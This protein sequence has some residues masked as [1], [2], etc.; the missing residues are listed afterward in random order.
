[1]N[2]LLCMASFA[3]MALPIVAQ[4]PSGIQVWKSADLKAYT[5]TLTAK[6]NAQKTATQ[7]LAVVDG[8]TT[9]VSHRE[10]TLDAEVHVNAA[11][12]DVVQSGACTLILGGTL[13]DGHST[14]AGEMKGSSIDGGQ[15][16]EVAAGDIINVPANTPHQ[17][18]IPAGGQITYFLMKIP[19]K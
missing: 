10:A 18:V 5:A 2:K 19:V 13:K 14:G 1:M 4:A 11:D 12:F 6:V 17:M 15:S 3:L 7:N 16:F 8:N 9:L